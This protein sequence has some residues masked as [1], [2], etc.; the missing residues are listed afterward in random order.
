MQTYASDD[1]ATY[2]SMDAALLL[3]RQYRIAPKLQQDISKTLEVICCSR[4]L[5]S[6]VQRQVHRRHKW[7]PVYQHAV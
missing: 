2:E 6:H 5:V 4:V 3:L 7:Q 1:L